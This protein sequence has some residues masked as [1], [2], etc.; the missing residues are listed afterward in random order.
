MVRSCRYS[1]RATDATCPNCNRTLLS[2]PP[3][4]SAASYYMCVSGARNNVLRRSQTP[5]ARD[6][7]RVDLTIMKI[8]YETARDNLCRGAHDSRNMR[9]RMDVT[10]LQFEH[11]SVIISRMFIVTGQARELEDESSE[12]AHNDGTVSGRSVTRF[13]SGYLHPLLFKTWV[14]GFP[15]KTPKI[16]QQESNLFWTTNKEV[17]KNDDNAFGKFVC[18]KINDLK[19][20][21]AKKKNEH[22]RFFFKQQNVS[23]GPLALME[24]NS[25]DSSVALCTREVDTAHRL[26]TKDTIP[27]KSQLTCNPTP[28]QD[29]I[30]KKISL[31]E[32]ELNTSI[33]RRDSG[34]GGLKINQEITKMQKNLDEAK[35]QLANKKRNAEYQKSFRKK[36][37]ALIKDVIKN[38]VVKQQ[39]NVHETVGRPRLEEAQPELLK[40]LAEIASFG[41]GAD[42]KRRT[43]MLRRASLGLELLLAMSIMQNAYLQLV[44]RIQA[45]SCQSHDEFPD[46]PPSTAVNNKNIDAVRRMNKTNRPTIRFA[47]P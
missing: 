31:V 12:S 30:E 39:L 11:C 44:F 35:K 37:Q 15:D 26:I 8:N 28:A 6:G 46:G 20:L 40:V 32:S 13:M 17:F 36:R 24:K 41:G 34:L 38:P 3:S 19:Q 33:L 16:C 18:Q 22:A 25:T 21:A 9:T 43:E 5:E 14:E 7:R 4:A 47:H 23:G 45:R 27:D 10:K 42:E 1:D 2:T 29:A